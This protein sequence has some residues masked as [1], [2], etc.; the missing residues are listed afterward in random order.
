MAD[1]EAL[2]SANRNR[3]FR[4][5]CRAVGHAEDARDLTQDVF[6]RVSRSVVPSGPEGAVRGW[7]FQIA[8]N[9]VLT[10]A[11]VAA[12]ARTSRRSPIRPFDPRRTTRARRSTRHLPGSPMST[13]MCS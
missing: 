6:V 9:L 2:Y 10:I 12:G 1:A 7:L 11:A 13:A 3:L 5:F 8:R 4:Y